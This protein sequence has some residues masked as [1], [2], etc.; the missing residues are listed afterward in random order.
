LLP[1]YLA[2]DLRVVFCGTAAGRR[3]GE[4]GH[5]YA[6]RGN[7]FWRALY[8]VGLTPER[9]SY[10]EDAR[11]LEYGVGLTDLAKGVSG[12]DRELPAGALSP[13]R[14][15][16]VVAGWQPRILAFNGLNAGR[17]MLGKKT[18]DRYGRYQVAGFPPIWI[19]PST[20]GAANAHWSIELWKELAQQAS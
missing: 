15:Q 7:K 2:K 10:R 14:L 9:L 4:V 3:S 16:S 20:S 12:M 19:L 8:E 13:G 5:Y 18:V 17:A 1:D 11:I 6:G